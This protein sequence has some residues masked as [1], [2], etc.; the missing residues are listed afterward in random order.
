MACEGDKIASYDMGQVCYRLEG[1]PG[2]AKCIIKCDPP[3]ENCPTWEGT[4]PR[5]PE[6]GD[7]VT[8]VQPII[9]TDYKGPK[10]SAAMDLAVGRLA[11]VKNGDPVNG[12]KLKFTTT[13]KDILDQFV[14]PPQALKL[15]FPGDQAIDKMI[16][17]AKEGSVN[18]EM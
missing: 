10:W 13:S 17:T 2:C 9:T 5:D 14:Y 12:Y 15:A 16:K 8:V 4:K 1:C 18:E 11:W 3:C 7:Y 6:P